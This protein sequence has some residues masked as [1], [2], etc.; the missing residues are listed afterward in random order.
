MVDKSKDILPGPDEPGA[1]GVFGRLAQLYGCTKKVELGRVLGMQ[2]KAIW[3]AIDRERIPYRHIVDKIPPEK[4]A[5]VFKGSE[6]GLPARPSEVGT[7]PIASAIKTL[8]DSGAYD[9]RPRPP[10]EAE[11]RT[12]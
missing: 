2:L 1:N 11:P 9:V 4:W 7:D 6:A 10:G 8:I 12:P 5:Y 3:A